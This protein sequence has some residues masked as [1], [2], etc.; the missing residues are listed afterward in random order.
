MQARDSIYAA[1]KQALNLNV[2]PPRTVRMIYLLPNDRTFRASVVDSMKKTIREMQTFFGEQMRAHGYGYKTFN[3]ETDAQ[4]ELV[5][6]RVDGQQPDRNYLHNTASTVQDEVQQAFDLGANIYLI[7]IDNSINALGSA[8][9]RTGGTGSV[10]GE[11]GGFALVHGGFTLSTATHELGHALGLDHDFNSY[12]YIMSYG[13]LGGGQDRLSA[14][15][16]RF[17]AMH[18]S[19]NSNIAILA[20]RQLSLYGNHWSIGRSFCANFIV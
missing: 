3:I 1:N 2:G 15:N 7:V 5:V 10:G 11:S 20:D 14:C 19:F 13:L 16:A 17:L 6:H 18:P 12:E 8:G 4:G 9:Q